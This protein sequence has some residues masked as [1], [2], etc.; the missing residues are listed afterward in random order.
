MA[1]DKKKRVVPSGQYAARSAVKEQMG[2]ADTTGMDPEMAATIRG[3]AGRR[4]KFA[5]VAKPTAKGTNAVGDFFKKMF[6][7]GK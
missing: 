2:G 5:V 3:E 6:K 4:A 7:K 1:A